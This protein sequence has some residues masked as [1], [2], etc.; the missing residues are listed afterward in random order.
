MVDPQSA[1]ADPLARAI[2]GSLG[3]LGVGTTVLS[4][5]EWGTTVDCL[6]VPLRKPPAGELATFCISDTGRDVLVFLTEAGGA[7]TLVRRIARTTSDATAALEEA[8]IVVR[9]EVQALLDGR[10]VGLT[11]APP[12]PRPHAA[13]PAP[14]PPEP[15]ASRWPWRAG[16]RHPVVAAALGY[17][18]TTFGAGA[19]WQSGLAVQAEGGARWLYGVARYTFY[20]PTV[21]GSPAARIVLTRHPVELAVGG[22][23]EGPVAFAAQVGIEADDVVRSTAGT[24]TGLSATADQAQWIWAATA[25]AGVDWSPLPRLRVDAGGGADVAFNR[26]AYVVAPR[27]ASPIVST[28]SVR[29]RVEVGVVVDVW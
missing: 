7:L 21:A 17:V 6:G 15:L 11:A 25:L 16:D 14:M 24:G 4:A 10:H 22:R 19:P 8:A 9:T 3:E 20:A 5:A 12:A 18:G 23:T 13:A 28:D 1:H 29:A 27:A 2:R 26:V